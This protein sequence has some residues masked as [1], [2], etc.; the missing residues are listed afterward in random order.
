MV[1]MLLA[2][3]ANINAMYEGLGAF[4][5]AAFY[6]H[7]NI[8]EILLSNGLD[9]NTAIKTPFHIVAGQGSVSMVRF[10]LECAAN[11]SD[12]NRDSQLIPFHASVTQDQSS[13]AKLLIEENNAFGVNARSNDGLTPA[14]L[15]AREGHADLVQM[16]I[17]HGADMCIADN[18]GLT[19][20][21]RA[22]LS[23]D[24]ETFRLLIKQEA[25]YSV[26]DEGPFAARY[27]RACSVGHVEIVKFL[28]Q[29]NGV[30]GAKFDSVWTPLLFACAKPLTDV[31]ELLLD[32]RADL[33]AKNDAGQAPLH[34]ASIQGATELPS[35]C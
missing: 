10:L 33:T 13:V 34:I 5:A 16:L 31:V 1:R 20:F 23:G 11:M 32:A 28:P 22:A 35:H 3:G 24:V 8:S 15:A 6:C 17:D 21:Q 18:T 2:R 30:L 7:L 9:L 29:S 25:R 19:T 27:S 4:H 26:L 14:H 12:I